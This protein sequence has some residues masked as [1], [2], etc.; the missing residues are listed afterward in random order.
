MEMAVDAVCSLKIDG[1][2]SLGQMVAAGNFDDISHFIAEGFS[3]PQ[4]GQRSVVVKIVQ[5][6]KPVI[7]TNY[8]L[9]VLRVNRLRPI[10]IKE[11]LELGAQ[12]PDLQR[13]YRIVG[14][15]SKRCSVGTTYSSPMLYCY[16]SCRKLGLFNFSLYGDG[17]GGSD[18]RFGAVDIEEI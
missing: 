6:T 8:V 13:R 7:S 9:Q 2:K 15:G 12:Y 10:D 11:L 17:Y 14:L 3:E 1:T 16:R 18:F 4:R 5:I